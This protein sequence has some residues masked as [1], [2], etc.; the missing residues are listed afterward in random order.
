M[1]HYQSDGKKLL[2][3]EYDEQPCVGDTLDS[4][5]I[6]SAN[7]R[8]GDLALFLQEFDGN[9]A[10]FVLDEIFIVGRVSGFETLVDAVDA[11]MSD[12]I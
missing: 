9:V 12:E 6:I 1:K 3:V 11:W 8:D 2:H 7:E 10:V 5:N 4:M